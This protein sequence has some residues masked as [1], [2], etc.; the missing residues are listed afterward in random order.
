MSVQPQPVP[1]ADRLRLHGLWHVDAA[2]LPRR[3]HAAL[4]ADRGL[5]YGR[6]HVAR[7]AGRPRGR[8]FAKN[9]S[10]ENAEACCSVKNKKYNKKNIPP[11]R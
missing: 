8:G 9:F 6:L 5:H 1:R 7:G 4:L 3:A 10:G 11:K 2:Q